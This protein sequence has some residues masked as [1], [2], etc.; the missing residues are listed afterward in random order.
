MSQGNTMLYQEQAAFGHM[1][2]GTDPNATFKSELRRKYPRDREGAK[3]EWH[4]LIQHQA[5][6][7][8]LISQYEKE[9]KNM[10]SQQLGHAY[11]QK[12]H[13]E[14]QAKEQQLRERSQDS[15]IMNNR[16]AQFQ[17]VTLAHH[18]FLATILVWE[19]DLLLQDLAK[20]K[21]DKQSLQH[22]LAE[23]YDYFM[24]ELQNQYNEEVKACIHSQIR[25]YLV[26]MNWPL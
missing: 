10:R 14:I 11:D 2:S 24:R 8:Q 21:L 26:E 23:S 20:Q 13:E 3:N 15:L 5:E 6:V 9:L 4:A 1:T 18:S 19:Y 25:K 22:I 16:I 7:N 17:N 12:L